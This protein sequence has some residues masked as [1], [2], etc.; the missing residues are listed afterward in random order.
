MKEEHRRVLKELG[1]RPGMSR[2]VVETV[3][4]W[5]NLKNIV[6]KLVR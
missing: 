3:V 2:L 4:K 5:K 6:T 1:I